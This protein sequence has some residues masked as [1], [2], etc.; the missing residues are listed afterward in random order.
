MQ[1]RL[2]VGV[3]FGVFEAGMPVAGLLLG[4]GLASS[5]GHAAHWIGAGLLIATGLYALVQ[6][7]RDRDSHQGDDSP[8]PDA[9]PPLGRMLVTGL[10]LSIDNLAVRFALLPRS[11]AVGYLH[12][13][14]STIGKLEH[15]RSQAPRK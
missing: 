13:Y 15:G 6:A 8:V 14:P 5:L 10:A 9:G 11:D 2:R 3:V 4:H 7:A 12:C 1:T